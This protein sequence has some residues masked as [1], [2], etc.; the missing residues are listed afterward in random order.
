MPQTSVQYV[1]T[2]SGE[3][4]SVI[5]PIGLWREIGLQLASSPKTPSHPLLLGGM[6][7]RLLKARKRTGGMPL[8]DV[9][10]QFGLDRET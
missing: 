3:V 9:L 5:V 10:R 6:R 4:T 7:E 1:S 8:D 2:E